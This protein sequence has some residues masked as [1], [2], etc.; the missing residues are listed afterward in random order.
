MNQR[1][2]TYPSGRAGTIGTIALLLLLSTSCDA[3]DSDASPAAD[4]DSVASAAAADAL[5]LDVADKLA[6]AEDFSFTAE[7]HVDPGAYANRDVAEDATV[8]VFVSRPERVYAES[9][10]DRGVRKLYFDGAQVTVFDSTKNRFALANV[11]GSIDD[12]VNWLE[13][14]F[15]FSPPL[16]EFIVSDLYVDTESRINSKRLR[17]TTTV[18]SDTCQRLAF[19]AEETDGELLVSEATGLPCGLNATVREAEGN[20]EIRVTFTSWDLEADLAEDMFTFEPPPGA[21]E[22]RMLTRADIDAIETAQAAAAGTPQ[23][24][25][26]P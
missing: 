2:W 26:T 7:R 16:A 23:T 24:G 9:R 12:M 1:N 22:I 14:Q 6:S 20:P 15:A 5:L 17:G 18:G 10:S 19:H 21:K 11:E 3:D 25:A 4:P 13:E 8:R